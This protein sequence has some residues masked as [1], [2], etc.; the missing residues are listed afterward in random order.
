MC[1]ITLSL[2]PLLRAMSSG[3]EC[4]V[5]F[6]SLLELVHQ[7]VLKPS[8]QIKGKLPAFSKQVATSVG[9]VVHAA[10]VLKG[11]SASGDVFA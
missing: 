1:V 11:Q 9:E 8:A 3:R 7:I 10:E 2:S 6:K 5:A 4:V